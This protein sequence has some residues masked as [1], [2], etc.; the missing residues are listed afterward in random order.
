M[1]TIGPFSCLRKI[2]PV[3]NYV[4]TCGHYHCMLSYLHIPLERRMGVPRG[5]AGLEAKIV[6]I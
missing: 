4:D 6:K 1:Y 3:T 2:N 5:E